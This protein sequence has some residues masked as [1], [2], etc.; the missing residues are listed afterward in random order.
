MTTFTNIKKHSVTLGLSLLLLCLGQNSARALNLPDVPLSVFSTVENNVL[1][2]FDD[3]G[4]MAWG[5]LPDGIGG[6]ITTGTAYAGGATA[7]TGNTADRRACSNTF[8][9]IAYNPTADY[10]PPPVRTNPGNLLE[11]TPQQNLPNANF[12]AAPVNGFIAGSATVNLSTSYRP[13]WRLD[14]G[15]NLLTANVYATCGIAAAGVA[16]FYYVYDGI[17]GAVN[18]GVT[19]PTPA[20]TTSNGCYR[21]VQHG[22]ALYGGAWSSTGNGIANQ[23]QNFANWYSYYRVRNIAAKSAT[24]PRK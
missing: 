4:S 21:R 23:Q 19:C 7:T 13:V 5:F 18:E 16:A 8:N 12:F 3:S 11:T 24:G 17:A 10:T 14:V 22:V 15:S 2:T 9:G 20:V 6:N 1:L